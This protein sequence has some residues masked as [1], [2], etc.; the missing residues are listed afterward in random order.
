[1]VCVPAPSSAD[2]GY[3]PN[4]E[5]ES[6]LANY[7]YQHGGGGGYDG[8]AGNGGSA[9]VNAY[10]DANHFGYYVYAASVSFA[11]NFP[12]S[13]G[14]ITIKIGTNGSNDPRLQGLTINTSKPKQI[15]IRVATSQGGILKNL[16]SGFSAAGTIAGAGEIFT[17]VNAGDRITYTTINGAKAWVSTEKVAGALHAAGNLTLGAGVAIDVILSFA[18]E[19]SWGETLLNTTV[20]LG[21]VLIGGVPGIVIGVGYVIL[22]KTGMLEGP[23]GP[24]P[25]YSPPSITMP[26]ATRVERPL[27]YP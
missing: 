19:Q 11:Y 2:V 12:N 23:T 15:T 13:N 3:P 7:N 1:M 21:A 18:G 6:W 27:I 17:W 16:N 25:Y 24:M 10:I 5:A 22:D 4:P 14:T 8:V 9:W 20:G 26:D